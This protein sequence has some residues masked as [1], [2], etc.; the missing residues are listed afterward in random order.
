MEKLKHIWELQWLDEHWWYV[1][2]W[3]DRFDEIEEPTLII[4]SGGES[5]KVY[6]SIYHEFLCN[7]LISKSDTRLRDVLRNTEIDL[8]LE[9]WR[10]KYQCESWIWGRTVLQ[11]EEKIKVQV[12]KL[13][14]GMDSFPGWWTDS[15]TSV[16]VG[17][18]DGQFR[19]KRNRF[20][21]KE[22][23][24][25]DTLGRKWSEENKLL[26]Q[27]CPVIDRLINLVCRMLDWIGHFISRIE[28]W[29]SRVRRE[30]SKL[31]FSWMKICQQKDLS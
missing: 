30:W 19:S 27:S 26:L 11:E 22:H 21:G 28:W 2:M 1:I 25:T 20:T 12:W 23:L 6:R 7:W 13:E 29:Y 14:M 15:S 24:S 3:K 8:P 16:K 18:G 17:Y 31:Q 4:S 5:L 10:L 9:A